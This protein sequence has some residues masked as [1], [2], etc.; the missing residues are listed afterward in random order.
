G[1]FHN[2]PPPPRG[3]LAGTHAHQTDKHPLVR[4]LDAEKKEWEPSV[5]LSDDNGSPASQSS[6]SGIIG[7]DRN[8]WLQACRVLLS[9]SLTGARH[10]AIKLEILHAGDEI[11]PCAGSHEEEALAVENCDP[12]LR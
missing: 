5:L 9:P 12:L 6:V 11:V 1:R 3:L 4:R 7:R 8:K 10:K 2:N